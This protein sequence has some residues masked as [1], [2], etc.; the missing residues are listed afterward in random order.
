MKS[1]IDELLNLSTTQKNL[2]YRYSVYTPQE[3]MKDIL[4]EDKET[5][6][7]IIRKIFGIDKYKKIIDNS[8]IISRHIKTTIK[9]DDEKTIGLED[10][11]IRLLEKKNK[12]ENDKKNK[13]IYEKDL[14]K[15]KIK[16]EEDKKI[17]DNFEKQ[18]K[19]F[20]EKHNQ[21]K[22]KLEMISQKEK[23][24]IEMS[25]EIT[26][27][28]KKIKAIEEKIMQL[29]DNKNK[30][31]CS[32][33]LIN[34]IE[35]RSNTQNTQTIA[36][37]TITDITTQI[38]ELKRKYKEK[39]N[40]I[41]EHINEIKITE[42]KIKNTNKNLETIKQDKENHIKKLSKYD[43]D[44]LS[45]Q[46][47]I[48]KIKD[49]MSQEDKFK[50]KLKETEIEIESLKKERYSKE[51][52]NRNNEKLI[53]K[54]RSIDFC[55]TC[56]Q[57]VSDEHKHHITCTATDN[58]NENLKKIKDI[59]QNLEI[60]ET[61][62]KFII[63]KLSEIT[64]AKETIKLVEKEEETIRNISQDLTNSIEKEKSLY[65][66]K[67]KLDTII[68]KLKLINIDNLKEECEIIEKNIEELTKMN[69]ISQEIVNYN[70]DLS[71]KK[72]DILNKKEKINALLLDLTNKTKISSELN[73]VGIEIS[74]IR[75]TITENK[76]KFNLIREQ[77][78]RIIK[79]LSGIDKDIEYLIR[80]ISDLTAKIDEKESIKNKITK[81]KEKNTWLKDKF[82]PTMNLIEKNLM[83]Q[84]NER[85]N[86]RFTNWFKTMIEDEEIEAKISEDFTP[87]VSIQGY[88][89]EID[90]MS[91]GEKTSLALAY[92]LALN[93]IISELMPKTSLKDIVI[94]DEPTDGFSSEQLDK[95]KEVLDL[96]DIPQLIIV[97]H[98]TKIESYVD[99]II[100]LQKSNHSTKII[101]E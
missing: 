17:L 41:N 100:R 62:K 92:R 6:Q 33:E 71:E 29:K 23:Q 15:I 27:L 4:F 7:N 64:T 90:T 18:E 97:S 47:K 16:E 31:E 89:T 93:K 43:T 84:I 85:F 73:D 45:R 98:E 37:N 40:T 58:S 49:T 44:E 28:E 42:E 46:N 63:D 53:I 3:S 22:L 95:M 79:E 55:P 101:S 77:E 54:I 82:V 78:T 69:E 2:F 94:L 9:F 80:D 32:L 74:K 11:K 30:L 61:K 75:Q 5:L 48:N 96:L 57:N 39:L 66:E 56:M 65:L 24:S 8:E 14:E 25:S 70:N 72:R 83:I 68:S 51:N 38:L 20:I 19:E 26:I 91:G 13:S 99:N 1:K 21:L 76:Q 36:N 35:L 52:E 81:L 34:S 59:V 10:D 50:A 87:Q 60:L 12:L 88:D 67:E 86:D